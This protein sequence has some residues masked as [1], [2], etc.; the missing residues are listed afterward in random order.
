MKEALLYQQLPHQQV[1]CGVCNHRCIIL[2]G[3]RGLCGT[4]QNINGKLYSLVFGKAVTQEVDPIEKKPFFHFLPGS[5]T[6]SIATV[7]CSFRCAW[8]QNHSISQQP[9]PNHPVMGF[10]LSPDEIVESARRYSCQSVA[11]TYT[12]PSIFLEYA[13]ET[14]KLAHQEKIFNLWVSNGYFTPQTLELIAPYLDAINVDLKSFQEKT[15][16]RYIGGKLSPVL[17]NLIEIAKRKIHLEVTTLVIPGVNDSEEELAQI[18]QFIKDKLGPSTVWHLTR[19]FPNYQMKNKPA[20][21][22]Q[23]LTR[24]FE[25][26]KKVGLLFVYLG[27]VLDSKKESTY[28]PNC[29]ELIIKRSGYL[30]EAAV[31]LQKNC[32][33]CKQDLNLKIKQ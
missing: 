1:R 9:K 6:F 26:G 2:K 20:T 15:Y 27:N 8:C 4:R 16:N 19:F 13:L 28:C 12:E 25:I 23:I 22:Y 14:M 3:E 24:A 32:P 29:G 31:N 5:L 7:G 30:V 21:P 18:A 11:F 17:E 10:S 33:K